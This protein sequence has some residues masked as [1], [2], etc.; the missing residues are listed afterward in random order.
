ME[1]KVLIKKRNRK[2][3]AMKSYTVCFLLGLSCKTDF[4]EVI[5]K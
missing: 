2:Y 1:Y 3:I 4:L 5:H